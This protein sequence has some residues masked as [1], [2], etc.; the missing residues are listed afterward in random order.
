[1][2]MKKFSLENI[3]FNLSLSLT[4]GQAFRWRPG[5]AD[6]W[7]APVDGKLWRVRQKG[8]VLYY[9]GAEEEEVVRYFALDIDLEE[10]L[11]DIDRDAL[12]HQAI[13]RCRGLRIL[14]QPKW[15]CLVSYICSSCANIPCIQNRI[16]NLSE[17]FGSPVGGERF[18]FPKPEALAE[19]APEDIRACR[20]GYR[21]VYIADAAKRCAGSDFLERVGTLPY[22]EA[23]KA[24]M[25]ICGVGPKVADCVLLFSFE[26]YEAVPVD[27]WIERILRTKYAGGKSR[28][29]YEKA[30]GFTRE[31]FGRFAGYAQ[32]Y[33]FGVREEIVKKG[34]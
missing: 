29:S 15:E 32:E 16:E 28:L 33:L 7:S 21:D 14:R 26:R 19:A 27:V 25:E 34:E 8:D 12:I 13:E 18:A 9:A 31:H 30:G 20:T 6:I 5:D 4:C 17:K 10:I 22:E 23:K 3:P 1:M 2:Q 11:A 24:L